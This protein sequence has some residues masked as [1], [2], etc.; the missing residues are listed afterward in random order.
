MESAC[1]IL[2]PPFHFAAQK[3][4]TTSRT[5]YAYAHKLQVELFCRC[6]EL[7]DLELRDLL[8]DQAGRSAM[9]LRLGGPAAEKWGEF[10]MNTFL[11]TSVALWLFGSHCFAQSLT[12]QD[13]EQRKT[14]AISRFQQAIRQNDARQI[15][16]EW[17]VVCHLEKNDLI[18]L[19]ELCDEFSMPSES[20]WV[21]SAIERIINRS[22]GSL[23]VHAIELILQDPKRP[24]A[25]S[26]VALAILDRV[27]PGYREKFLVTVEAECLKDL[28]PPRYPLGLVSQWKVI[29]PLPSEV[30]S[31]TM[32]PHPIETQ[33]QKRALSFDKAVEFDNKEW[34]WKSFKIAPD[35]TSLNFSE[36]F[37]GVGNDSVCFAA[38]TLKSNSKR[39]VH[40]LVSGDQ[41]IQLWLNGEMIIS[42]S[43]YDEQTR[44]QQH[45]L[46]AE[47][48]KG[49][50]ELLIK[51]L[52]N[53]GA[54]G[55]VEQFETSTEQRTD[56][57]SVRIVE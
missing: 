11:R 36:I 20:A 31:L 41:P 14:E 45:R 49:V 26:C 24:V 48:K 47:L 30:G 3:L 28:E 9:F 43:D 12:S 18:R 4:Y 55:A 2:R 15:R 13:I 32:Q 7:R 29:G 21:T 50:N 17:L 34:Q 37:E 53:G 39:K 19:I 6:L 23:D 46:P 40:I 8:V 5:C 1:T 54:Y 38:A 33:F 25:S 56:E 16:S 35:A 44:V 27:Q 42:P 51:I 52:I 57:L 22:Q 10:S